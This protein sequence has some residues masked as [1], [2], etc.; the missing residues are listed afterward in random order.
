MILRL[1][2]L[3]SASDEDRERSSTMTLRSTA[4]V[5]VGTD[6]LN[7]AGDA[8]VAGHARLHSRTTRAM[9]A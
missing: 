8:A 9:P 6:T 5:V 2:E 4:A 7:D 3:V 1:G